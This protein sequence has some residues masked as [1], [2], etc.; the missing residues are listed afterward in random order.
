MVWS[1]LRENWEL[2]PSKLDNCLSL[3]KSRSLSF[4]GKVLILNVLGRRKLLYLSRVLIPPRWVLDRYNSLIWPFLWG[5]KLEPVAR[6]SIVCSPD[7]G[8]LGLIDFWSKG[9]ALRLSSFVK[10]LSDP[11]LKC[12][13]LV[14][15]FCSSRLATLRP[16]WSTLRDIRTPNAASPSKFYSLMIDLLMHFPWVLCI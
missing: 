9:Q 5:A 1:Q 15:Y 4:V 7:Q 2:R 6:R 11:S 12:F 14:R 16:E 8:G 10:S 13:Y 3:W